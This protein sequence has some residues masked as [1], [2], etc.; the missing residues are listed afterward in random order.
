[1]SSFKSY[2]YDFQ[3][4]KEGGVQ[5]ITN[6]LSDRQVAYLINSYRAK[7]IDQRIV[8]KVKIPTVY[9]QD[10]SSGKVPVITSTEADYITKDVIPTPIRLNYIGSTNRK[11]PYQITDPGKNV[12]EKESKL[13]GCLPKYYFRQG[14]IY[15]LNHKDS[16]RNFITVQGIFEDPQAAEHYNKLYNPFEEYDFEYPIQIKDRDV[17]FKMILDS[18]LRFLSTMKL[19]TSNNTKDD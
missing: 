5:T 7:L 1:M 16:T 11:T 14:K 3:N 9:Q 10:L 4:L 6:S 18:E 19:D 17:I 13:T 2:I 8:D 15:L 12:W